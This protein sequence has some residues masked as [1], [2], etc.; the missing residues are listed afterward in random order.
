MFGPW[1]NMFQTG[2]KQCPDMKHWNTILNESII[3]ESM[4]TNNEQSFISVA[5]T[6]TQPTKP[7]KPQQ[8]QKQAFAQQDFHYV[9]LVLGWLN[10]IYTLSV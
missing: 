5:K 2:F 8:P 10:I 7:Q 4:D 9:F 1:L 3:L 6:Q